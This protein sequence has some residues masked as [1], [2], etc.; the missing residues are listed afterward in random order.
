MVLYNSDLQEVAFSDALKDGTL[1]YE[2]IGRWSKK[3]GNYVAGVYYAVERRESEIYVDKLA[4][5]GDVAIDINL[6]YRCKGGR[7]IRKTAL[8]I[9]DK[10][11]IEMCQLPWR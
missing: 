1:I 5:I 6:F 7:I 2:L 9:K 3:I 8:L 4:C 11:F 10:K